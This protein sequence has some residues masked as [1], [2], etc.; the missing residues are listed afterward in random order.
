M[1]T[2]PY[3]T[4]LSSH[5]TC[6]YVLVTEKNRLICDFITKYQGRTDPAMKIGMHIFLACTAAR[7]MFFDVQV[8]T[9]LLEEFTLFAS[10]NLCYPTTSPCSYFSTI[11]AAHLRVY[12]RTMGCLRG[13][14]LC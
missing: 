2:P 13:L 5:R 7:S 3:K 4:S 10:A 6:M 1:I 14:R 11:F 12:T 8:L 9:L